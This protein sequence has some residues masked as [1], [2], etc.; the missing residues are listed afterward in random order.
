MIDKEIHF[1]SENLFNILIA[2]PMLIC[3]TIQ[4]LA[5]VL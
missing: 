4:L 2:K 3:V 1:P 5:C